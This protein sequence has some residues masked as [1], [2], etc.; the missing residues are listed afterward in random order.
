MGVLPLQFAEGESAESL[1]LTGEEVF[2]IAGLEGNDGNVPRE[3]MVKAGDKEFTATVR[4]DTP[5]EQ[6]YYRHGGILKYVLRELLSKR[7]TRKAF[8]A[9]L[10]AAASLAGAAPAH[11]A[12]GVVNVSAKPADTTAGAHS[13]FSLHMEFSS[14]SDDVKDVVIHLPAGLLGDPNATPRCTRAQY[15]G[16]AC[17]ANTK[18]GTANHQGLHPARDPGLAR[19]R[20]QPRAKRLGAG[21]AGDHLQAAGRRVRDAALRVGR[22]AAAERL[23]PRHDDLEHP[24]DV[25]HLRPRRDLHRRHAV[26]QGGQ[27]RQAVHDQPDVLR[28]GEDDRRGE[29]LHQPEHDGERGDVLHPDPLRRPPLR[30][31]VRGLRDRRA[32]GWPSHAADH[33][34]PDRWRSQLAPDR[35]DAAEPSSGR[36]S[37]GSPSPA[38]RREFDAGTCDPSSI[39]GS[40]KAQTPIF[41]QPLQGG[42][43]IVE[44]PGQ[45][46]PALLLELHGPLDI[47][48]RAGVAILPDGRLKTVFPIIPDVPISHLELALKGGKTGL[49]TATKDFCATPVP[50]KAAFFAHSGATRSAK[51]N[52]TPVGCKLKGSAALAGVARQKPALTVNVT[53]GTAALRARCASRCR[54]RCARPRAR[55]AA[56]SRCPAACASAPGRARSSSPPA[57][58]ASARRRSASAPAP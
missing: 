10:A 6:E 4:I 40:V 18:L 45:P 29:V 43:R 2:E 46:L 50:I 58:P 20:L 12:F 35:G 23:R 5:K 19:R 22:L 3:L 11:A 16:D 37:P 8:P 31:E 9:L 56:P 14:P 47:T 51:V 15:D 54:L 13:N 21:A 55:G 41:A 39:V 44:A 24:P 27:S 49:L 42:V 33:D 1:G 26:R 30:A 57:R 25:Q 48:L 38:Q 28:P 17:P 36:T 34:R 52:A 7:L 32:S 53:A